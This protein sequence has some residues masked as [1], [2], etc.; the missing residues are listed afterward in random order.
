VLPRESRE[1]LREMRET[2]RCSVTAQGSRIEKLHPHHKQVSER[3]RS[4]ERAVREAG[5]FERDRREREVSPDSM[6]KQRVDVQENREDRASLADG[7]PR[8][9]STSKVANSISPW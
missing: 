9:A 1:N 5:V 7:G 3:S 6:F 2:S 4:L 8:G